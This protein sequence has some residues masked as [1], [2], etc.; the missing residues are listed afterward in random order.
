MSPPSV[1]QVAPLAHILMDGAP[2]GCCLHITLDDGN[3]EDSHVRSCLGYAV[4][5]GHPAC[6]MLALIR[7]AMTPDEGWDVYEALEDV[8]GPVV[9]PESS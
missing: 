6:Y 3:V 4:E 7:L 5:V 2:T 9:P 8:P 1:A